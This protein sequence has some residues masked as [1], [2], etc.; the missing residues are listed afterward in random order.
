MCFREFE[1]DGLLL[2]EVSSR[3]DPVTE[4]WCRSEDE[5]PESEAAF[6]LVGCLLSKQSGVVVETILSW[7]STQ[8]LH[9]IR[10]RLG[11]S[12]LMLRLAR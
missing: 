2:T 8:T 9:T 11:L 4:E 12:V 7:S 1:R 5:R 10:E 3:L 6:C